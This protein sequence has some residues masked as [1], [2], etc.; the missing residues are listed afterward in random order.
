MTN[1]EKFKAIVERLKAEGW[2]SEPVFIS[3]MMIVNYL[4]QLSQHGVVECA[5]NVTEIGKNVAAVCEEFDW[6]P[7]D[8]DILRFVTEMVDES[9]RAAFAY[10]IKRYR[11]DKNKFIKEIDDEM[12]K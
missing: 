9:D 2:C 5:Y 6:K 3:I 7:T 10:L 11:D 8:E 1:E 4:D 12:G